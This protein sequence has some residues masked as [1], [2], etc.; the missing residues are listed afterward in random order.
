MKRLSFVLAS[1][2][3][4]PFVASAR[5]LPDTG[6]TKCYDN[7]QEITCPNPGEPF[8]GQ[9]ANYAPCNTHSY[10]KLDSSSNALPDEA[11]E[12]AMVR[13]NV[14]GLIWE[15][16]TDD[17]TIHDKDN[18]YTWY[19]LQNE[20]ID[21]LNAQGFGG[22][23]DWRLPNPKE[24]TTIADS[25][26]PWPG[27]AISTAYFP[28][29][30]FDYYWSSTTHCFDYPLRA[31]RVGFSDGGLYGYLKTSSGVVRAVHGGQATNNFVDDGNGTVTDTDTGLIW[32]KETAPGI[33]SWEQAL[34]YCESLSLAGYDDW[35]LP[36]RNELQSI[37][38]Y[39]QCTP[40]IDTAFFLNTVSSPYWTSTSYANLDYY[41]A[42]WDVAFSG[43]E[44]NLSDKEDD[45]YVRCV[46]EGQCVCYAD[47]NDDQKVNLSDLVIMKQQ[48]MWN[49]SEHPSCEADCNYDGSVNLADLVMM[50]NEFLRTDCPV[51]L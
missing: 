24:L 28:N 21:I 25:N 43:G 51:C 20:F 42:A 26:I 22:Y 19:E 17:G 13:D 14:I 16:K 39:S 9:D 47:C 11:T 45:D 34:E 30:V 38:D 40:C 6:Q 3:I 27:P 18:T 8:Y 50:K 7:T 41:H 37:V 49:C 31:S 23:A 1:L 10:T 32:Q 35:R 33:Y 5:M 12:W 48:F 36:N 29:T 46:R 44:V 2:L 4:F 15:V